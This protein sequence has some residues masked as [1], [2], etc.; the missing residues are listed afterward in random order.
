VFGAIGGAIG[1]AL[2]VYFS[3]LFDDQL[4]KWNPGS[5]F[6][7]SFW[8]STAFMVLFAVTGADIEFRM[9]ETGRTASEITLSFGIV[10]GLLAAGLA[11]VLNNLRITRP[12][13]D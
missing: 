9:S 5:A 8:F 7:F 1:G 12:Q 13:L 10:A 4:I 11:G 2:G 3:W 6:L